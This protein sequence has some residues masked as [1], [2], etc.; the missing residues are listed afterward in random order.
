MYS[1]YSRFETGEPMKSFV[2]AAALSL[3]I[4]SAASAAI[5]VTTYEGVV[6]EG[7]DVAGIFG[8][9]G[10]AL[11]GL[12]YTAVFKIDTSINRNFVG[13][14]DDTVAADGVTTPLLSAIFTLN[15]I[16]FDVASF[17]PLLGVSI[18]GNSFAHYTDISDRMAFEFVVLSND[19]PGSLDTPFAFEHPTHVN[20]FISLETEDRSDVMF[21]ASLDI[22]RVTHAAAVPEP[23]TWTLMI[24]GFGTAGA[25]LRRRW[26]VPN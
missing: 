12:A 1:G 6:D 16:G 9:A 22:D 15:G 24:L 5:M 8:T 14:G 26:L 4:A 19:L 13:P 23:A 2:L 7:T 18:Q 25:M 20:T 3:G 10:A 21:A 17:S 11:D